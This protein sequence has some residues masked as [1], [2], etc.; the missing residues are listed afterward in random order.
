MQRIL[1]PKLTL[2]LRTTIFGHT[3]WSEYMKKKQSILISQ[4]RWEDN[5]KLHLKQT[6]R[7]LWDELCKNKLFEACAILI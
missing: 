5:I 1:N 6:G 2:T 7:S 3:L 4:H